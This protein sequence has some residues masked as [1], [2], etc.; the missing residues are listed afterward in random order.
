MRLKDHGSGFTLW[1]S[2]GETYDWARKP[3]AAWPCSTL[4]GKRIRADFDTNGLLELTIDG[5]TAGDVDGTELS[6]IIADHAGT[7]LATDHP[8]YFVAIG[9]F[10]AGA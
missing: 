3:G 2:A 6:A 8:C 5:R 9:Q 4:E 1:V 7:V 10:H